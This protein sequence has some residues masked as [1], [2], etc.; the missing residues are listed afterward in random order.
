MPRCILLTSLVALSSLASANATQIRP[1]A[2]MLRTPD[3]SRDAIVFRYAGD[4]WLVDKH[5]GIARS[6]SSPAG[7]ET[8]PKFSPDG[9]QIAFMAGY[10]GGSDIYVLSIDGG[11]PL[12][13]T[14]HPDREV[15]CD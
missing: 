3:V 5:G 2:V 12:R 7:P 14:H 13:V 11:I 6:L 1:D 9:K 8:N 10:D 15:L 4:L